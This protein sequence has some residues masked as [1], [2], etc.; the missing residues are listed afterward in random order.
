M[1]LCRDILKNV[2]TV[3]VHTMKVSGVLYCF[4]GMYWQKQ[5]NKQ[6]DKTH[7]FVFIQVWNKISMSKWWSDFNF[8]LNFPF[9]FKVFCIILCFVAHN[10]IHKPLQPQAFPSVSNF[11]NY[12]AFIAALDLCTKQFNCLKKNKNERSICIQQKNKIKMGAQRIIT[13]FY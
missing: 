9:I 1:S 8:W 12:W 4:F 2:W 6:T 3:S 13:A 5:A 7:F 11:E 10:K